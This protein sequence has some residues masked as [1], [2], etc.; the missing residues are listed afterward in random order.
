[1]GPD[2]L[3]LGYPWFAATNVKPNWAEGTLPMSV[4]IRTRG[5]AFGKPVPPLRVVGT[6][7]KI[8]KPSFMEEGD[9]LYIH[10][11]NTECFVKTTVAQQLAEQATDKTVRSWDQI[12]PPHYHQHA[13]VFSETAAHQFPDSREWNHA[14]DLKADAPL[15]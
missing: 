11:I 9:E 13:K 3:V 6:R 8:R 5:A 15:L 2:N 4:T 7:T 10:V 12:V 1:M 14:I